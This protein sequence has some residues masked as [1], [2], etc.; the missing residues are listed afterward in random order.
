M[1]SFGAS[2]GSVDEMED[3]HDDVSGIEMVSSES[4]VHELNYAV[5]DIILCST[6]AHRPTILTFICSNF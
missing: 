4:D 1:N 3:V 2:C 6:R 5:C